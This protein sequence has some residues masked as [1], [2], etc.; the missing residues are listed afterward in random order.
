MSNFSQFFNSSVSRGGGQGMNIYSN[1]KPPKFSPLG[2]LQ[3]INYRDGIT[4]HFLVPSARDNLIAL[5][6]SPT[7]SGG[8]ITV[9]TWEQDSL[10]WNILE[11]NL[12]SGAKI[13]GFV[14]NNV[15]DKYYIGISGSAVTSNNGLSEVNITTGALT[16]L[17]TN[18]PEFF[19]SS[20]LLGYEGF[21]SH[22]GSVAYVDSSG[23]YVFRNGNIFKKYNTSF[24][25]IQT[26]TLN[27][28]FSSTNTHMDFWYYTE[29]TTLRVRP[30]YEYKGAVTALSSL[31]TAMKPL[32]V[33]ERAKQRRIIDIT[34][35]EVFNARYRDDYA[36][37]NAATVP[38]YPN[39]TLDAW[40]RAIAPMAPIMPKAPFF[41]NSVSLGGE[42]RNQ[43]V[44][45]SDSFLV[46]RVDYDRWLNDIADAAGMRQPIES[47]FGSWVNV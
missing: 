18:L 13:E 20:I 1:V 8:D 14:Y 34:S 30:V 33:I 38:T 37:W 40:S 22:Q 24:M 12:G 25:P 10:V 43:T 21:T 32:L 23:N 47:F 17:S 26:K 28:S 29:D 36:P 9:S 4:D 46:D 5:N 2:N 39:N 7:A 44:S 11:T 15:L 41:G 42:T 3:N 19:N 16:R 6:I 35:I 45:M 27:S 31:V